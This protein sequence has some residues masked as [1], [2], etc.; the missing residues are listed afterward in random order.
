MMRRVLGPA[1]LL[2]GLAWL[3]PAGAGEPLMSGAA[4]RVMDYQL[5]SARIQPPGPGI[6]G[7]EADM[8][9][10]HYLGGGGR[11][12]RGAASMPPATGT[13]TPAPGRAGTAMPAGR[14]F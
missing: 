8:L 14:G 7:A 6:S 4:Q 1:V 3:Q 11:D 9:T 13:P 5:E 2:I 10:R 12:G